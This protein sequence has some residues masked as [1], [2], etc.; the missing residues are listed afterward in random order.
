MDA[1]DLAA[2]GEELEGLAARDDR[3][4]RVE[5]HRDRLSSLLGAAAPDPARVA[6]G[7]AR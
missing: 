1:G 2:A 3:R 5:A 7:P 6:D 4:E